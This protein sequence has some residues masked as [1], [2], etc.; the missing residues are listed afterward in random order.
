V[1]LLFDLLASC[2]GFLRHAA[3]T[4]PAAVTV[5]TLTFNFC[6]SQV[7]TPAGLALVVLSVSG[8]CWTGFERCVA[9]V[10]SPR[11]WRHAATRS[12]T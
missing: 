2:S 6:T 12:S 5:P 8:G 1:R 10:M 11:S 9:G 7:W 4:T 3:A